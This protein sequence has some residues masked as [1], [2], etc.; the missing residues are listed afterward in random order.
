MART[1]SI[2][3][4]VDDSIYM[5]IEIVFIYISMY[6]SCMKCFFFFL[7]LLFLLG[8]DVFLQ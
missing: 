8:I 6:V 5:C 2:D 4:I 1:G 7:L 3:L